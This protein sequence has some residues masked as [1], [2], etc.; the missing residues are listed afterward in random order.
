MRKLFQSLFG[1]FLVLTVCS[2]AVVA[3]EGKTEKGNA[4]ESKKVV[5]WKERTD[6]G[7]IPKTWNDQLAGG[8]GHFIPPPKDALKKKKNS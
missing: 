6:R 2:T 8:A 3:E 7:D 5:T 4:D 1:F